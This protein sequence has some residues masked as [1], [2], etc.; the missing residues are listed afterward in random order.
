M[1]KLISIF[2]L[3]LSFLSPQTVT[4]RPRFIGGTVIV[5]FLVM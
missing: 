2:A 5:V 4:V 3:L 1:K